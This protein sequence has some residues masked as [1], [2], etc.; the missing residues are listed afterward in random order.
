MPLPS[1]PLVTIDHLKGALEVSLAKASCRGS[2]T[3]NSTSPDS[4]G[5]GATAPRKQANKL[6]F[7]SRND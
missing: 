2:L 4:S 5:G 3:L 6:R 1:L 7:Q